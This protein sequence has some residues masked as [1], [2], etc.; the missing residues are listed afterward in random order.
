MKL[1]IVSGRPK[2]GG[3]ERDCIDQ[4]WSERFRAVVAN[5]HTSMKKKI[6]YHAGG[7]MV[8]NGD[9]PQRASGFSPIVTRRQI[10]PTS[11]ELTQNR[12]EDTLA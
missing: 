10:L 7:T 5:A 3:M 2:V 12:G 4:R 11:S 9:H 1:K 6:S 8:W